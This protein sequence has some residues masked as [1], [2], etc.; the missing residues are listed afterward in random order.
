[1]FILLIHFLEEIKHCCG[2]NMI[3]FVSKSDLKWPTYI[4]V[5]KKGI[6]QRNFLMFVNRKNNDNKNT[7]SF[8]NVNGQSVLTVLTVPCK[9]LSVSFSVWTV[10]CKPFSVPIVPYKLFRVRMV[11]YKP[12]S[13]RIFLCKPFSIRI[14][15]CKP[16]SVPLV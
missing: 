16:F 11:V 6:Q 1:V 10:P 4:F 13:V 7:E 14:V 3:Q 5:L 9:P 15:P 2:K 8:R 12:F